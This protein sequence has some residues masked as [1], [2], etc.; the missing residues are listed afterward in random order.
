[1]SYDHLLTFRVNA[2][3]KSK[4]NLPGPETVS[5]IEGLRL[6]K[7]HE[8]SACRWIHGCCL[9]YTHYYAEL[10]AIHIHIYGVYP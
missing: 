2:D 7:S 4:Y 5:L 1:M 3:I 6:N 10:S 8:N 9:P